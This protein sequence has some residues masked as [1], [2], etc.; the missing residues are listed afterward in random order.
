MT[1]HWC[2]LLLCMFLAGSDDLIAQAREEQ[3]LR[4][5]ARGKEGVAQEELV[6]FKNDLS[7]VEAIKALSEMS[8][9]FLNK[10]IVDPAPKDKPIGIGI[11][12]MYWRDALETI[13]RANGLWY[14]EYPDYF[15]IASAADIAARQR[16]QTTTTPLTPTTTTTLPATPGQLTPEQE[17]E[18]KA[19]QLAKSR[20]V[21]ISAVFL[22]VDRTK[23]REVGVSFSIFKQRGT[24]LSFEF[25]GAERVGSP[26]IE[27]TAVQTPTKQLS[28]DIESALRFFEDEALGE[29]IARP[30][31]TV[32]S[33]EKGLVQI[34]QDFSFRSRTI[35]GD[36][37]ETFYATGTILDVTPNVIRIG[38][39][40]FIDLTLK[41]ERSSVVPGAVTTII[42]KSQASS[43]LLLLDKEEAYVG[44][45]YVNEETQQRQG[46][47]ILKDLPWWF[48][49]LRYLFGS[50]AVRTA[51]KEL[52]VLIKAEMV[53]FIEERV[54]KRDAD[55]NLLQ[56][57][58][59][60]G[61]ED[62]I[63]RLRKN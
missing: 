43:K 12:A 46:I 55:R 36:V 31:V 52:I 33:G 15:A 35:S 21:T 62:T 61:R 3:Q 28:L 25:G 7:Y 16:Q 44:G 40:E 39:L 34:G 9:K 23:A 27:A 53:P 51:R 4:R 42:N 8:R 60:E 38:D 22:E 24:A 56:E 32:R 59:K 13:L 45:L 63:K 17:K 5:A 6:S 20:E 26:L 50:D 1:K 10:S 2:I 19:Q 37:T 57:R 11:D 41:V 18:Q 48:F 29:V 49:G 14:E 58:L 47:P 30:Q 54:S